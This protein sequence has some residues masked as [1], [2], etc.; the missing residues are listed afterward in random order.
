MDR[1][2]GMQV[3]VRVVERGSFSAVAREIGTTQSAVSKQVAGLESALGAR[4]LSRTTRSLALTDEGERYFERAR[5]LVAE[6]EEAEAELRDGAR[7]LKGWLRVAASVAFG[8]L[9]L[10]PLMPEFLRA[11]PDL[12]VDLRLDDGFVDLIEEGIDVAVRIG[13]LGDSGLVARRVGTTTR[14]VYASPAYLRRRGG[15]RAAPREPMDLAAHD[16]IVYT[17]LATRHQWTF[18]AGHGANQPSGTVQ[19]V[20]VSG[21]LQCNSSEVVREAVLSGLGLSH[22]PCWLFSTEVDRGEVLQLL[23]GWHSPDLPIHLVSPSQRRQS[24]KVRAFGDHVAARLDAN[25]Q[26]L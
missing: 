17:G 25:G 15:K 26:D 7:H 22:S 1:L 23:P 14:H 18:T 4:L 3:F 13:E 6:V 11:H 2:A 16:C 20:A 19:T 12:R 8:R 24:A 5:R 10:M 9:R 21:Q